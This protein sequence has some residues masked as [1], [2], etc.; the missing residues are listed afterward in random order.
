MDKKTVLQQAKEADVKVISFLYCDNGGIIRGKSTHISNL[1]GSLESGIGMSMAMPA[2][3]S[4]DTLQPVEGKGPVGEIRLVPDPNSFKILPYA[5]K[6][7]TMMCNMYSLD[8]SIW[9]SCTRNFL[10]RM[11][12]SAAAKGLIIK[13]VFEPE[14]TLAVKHKDG[15][16]APADESLCYSS[17]G[18]ITPRKV[19]EEIILALEAQGIG[20][21]QYYPELGH[22]Q[23]ELSIR[24]DDA[25]TAADN[26]IIYRETVRNVAWNNGYLVS[27]APKPFAEQAGNGCHIHFS[28]WDSTGSQNLFHSSED[29]ANISP[30]AYQF[31]NGILNHLPGLVAITCPSVNSYRR[32]KPQAWSSAFICYGP[33]NREAAIRIPSPFW[34]RESS[35]TNIELKAADATANPY[36]ALGGLIAA[37]LDG[38]NAGKWP[39]EDLF[40]KVDPATIPEDERLARGIHRLP[41]SLIKAVAALE[42][43]EILREA[44]GDDLFTSYVAVRKGEI[45]YYSCKDQCFE[46]ESH[47]YK[48]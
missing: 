3:S 12:D 25:L 35:S 31:I 8:H 13:A 6:W 48:Y 47:F 11:I 30:L 5:P 22:G 42:K 26:Q 18:M 39:H 34:G 45:E 19:I 46:M 43:D 2:M 15:N 16:Y 38:I 40:L 37:G 17:I 23:Q 33:D 44:L 41:D 36:L 14:W 32:L 7:A 27:F 1:E 28:I 24:F 9:P 20:I 21:E 29:R 10:Q 4:I